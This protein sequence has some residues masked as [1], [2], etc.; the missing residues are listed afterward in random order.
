MK[1]IEFNSDQ[2]KIIIWILLYTS[3]WSTLLC[4]VCL[5]FW[6]FWYFPRWVGGVKIK[7]KD[8][9]SPAK[10]GVEAELG[11]KAFCTNESCQYIWVKHK[12]A[13]RSY[14]KTTKQQKKVNWKIL[15]RLKEQAPVKLGQAHTQPDWVSLVR[16]RPVLNKMK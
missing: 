10:A 15:E 12:I 14:S 7:I 5:F 2:K 9:L 3:I 1:E 11:N 6:P 16:I 4:C 8:Q 13:F